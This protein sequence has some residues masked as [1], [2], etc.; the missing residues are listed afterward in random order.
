[1]IAATTVVAGSLV[2][3]V[4]VFASGDDDDARLDFCDGANDVTDTLADLDHTDADRV[5]ELAATID[6]TNAPAEIA[7][8]WATMTAPYL[9]LASGDLADTSAIEQLAETDTA[10][11]DPDDT[12]DYDEIADKDL[13]DPSV[14]EDL[15]QRGVLD[16][17]A[18]RTAN[19]FAQATANVTTYLDQ[20]CR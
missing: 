17:P 10:P 14:L 13:T 1:M 19:P 15:T 3:L 16:D 9:A 12:I 7:D 20:Q 4:V 11:D 8:D 5:T 2:A 18:G 6:R